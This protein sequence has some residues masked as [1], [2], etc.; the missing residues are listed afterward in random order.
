M[1]HCDTGGSEH[2]LRDRSLFGFILKTIENESQPQTQINPKQQGTK[3]IYSS[4]LI[5][6][7]KKS[8][9]NLVLL[10]ETSTLNFWTILKLCTEQQNEEKNK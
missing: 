8:Y 9:Y 6:N 2:F 5:L 10:T 3:I 4:V 1:W 7:L